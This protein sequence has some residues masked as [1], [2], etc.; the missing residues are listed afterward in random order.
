MNRLNEIKKD[1][2]SGR[3]TKSDYIVRM[4]EIHSG[5]FDYAEFIE[6][7]NISSIEVRNNRVICTFR[8]SGIK[9]ICN[10][11]DKRLAPF[12]TLNFGSYEM[13]ELEMQLNLIEP[14]YSV[15]DIGGN[16][17][18]YSMH[19]AKERPGAKIFTFEPIKSTFELLNENIRINRFTNIETFNYGFS[20]TEGEMTFYFDPALS[21]N[22]SLA[23]LSNNNQLVK[24][25]CYVKK[26]D[27]FI[28][29]KNYKV[30]FIKCDVEGAELLIYQGG[31]ELISNQRPV[32]F[33]EMLR[34]W[35]AKFNYHP[36]DI[37]ELLSGEEYGCYVLKNKKLKAFGLVDETTQDTNY[38]FL[39]KEKHIEKIMRFSE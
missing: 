17:G 39:H 31:M 38:F 27:N 37:I 3:I 28:K 4:Y 11:N 15:F 20:D 5:L 25:I 2:D 14:D 26:L 32:I 24:V 8:D 9:F 6:K 36:N 33:S 23:D 29:E 10:K 13:D 18:W 21:V 35:A 1:Y 16:L 34:K 30:D 7:T 19:V 22:A 12:D